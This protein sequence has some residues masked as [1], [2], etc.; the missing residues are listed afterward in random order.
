MSPFS[1]GIMKLNSIEGSLARDALSGPM[2]TNVYFNHGDCF[3]IR[4]W[5]ILRQG[6]ASRIRTTYIVQESG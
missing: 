5:M 1:S 3:I 2:M 4:G 6:F